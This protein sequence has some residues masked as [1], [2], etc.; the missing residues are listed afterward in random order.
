MSFF[1]DLCGLVHTYFQEIHHYNATRK[2]L[3]LLF[4]LF[5]PNSTN[6]VLIESKLDQLSARRILN[7]FRE[8]FVHNSNQRPV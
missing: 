8:L 5:R 7:E 6:S 3:L 4:S 1:N 2:F